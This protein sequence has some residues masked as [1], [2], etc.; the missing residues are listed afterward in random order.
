MNLPTVLE[1][2]RHVLKYSTWPDIYHPGD[3]CI[4]VRHV[5]KVIHVGKCVILH[6]ISHSHLHVGGSRYM[7]DIGDNVWKST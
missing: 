1:F 2:H 4:H 5:C 6:D 3:I 7:C